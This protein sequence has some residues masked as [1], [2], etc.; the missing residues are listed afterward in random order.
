MAS[1][2]PV[3]ISRRPPVSTSPSRPAARPAFVPNLAAIGRARRLFSL[4]AIA[5]GAILAIT[6]ALSFTGPAPA[7]QADPLVPVG[8]AM[9]TLALAAVGLVLTFGR[10]PSGVRFADEELWV[11]ERSGKI[12]R[13]PAP[14]A[15][16]MSVEERYPSGFL[17]ASPTHLVRLAPPNGRARR[18]VLEVGIL[19]GPF[20][21]PL[22][23]ERP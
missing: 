6:L 9:L 2:R 7:A 14:P 13:F 23:R 8:L 20:A 10:T 17:T 5:L 3:R 21:T 12:R 15:T 16:R 19:P 18:Y 1:P 4:Y 11:R 22:D